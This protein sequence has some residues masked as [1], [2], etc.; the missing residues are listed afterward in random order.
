MF[1]INFN[2]YKPAYNNNYVITDRDRKTRKYKIIQQYVND[3]FCI[4]SFPGIRTY[5]D[6][7]TK[8]ERKKPLFNVKWHSINKKNHLSY[9]NFSDECFAFVAGKCSGV[10]VIDVDDIK[11]YRRMLKKY[12]ELKKYRTIKTKKG[13]HIYC[14]YDQSIQTRTDSMLDYKKVDI[15][16]DLSLAFCPPSFYILVNG[17]RVDYTDLGGQILQ[18]PP[19]LKKNLK[20][21]HEPNLPQF[22]MIIN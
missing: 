13:V 20:Q 6:P 18:F 21:F 22:E 9:L 17:T 16:N 14:L 12:P 3:G 15:R 1:E 2:V 10:T 4:F 5:I 11:E 8:I 19:G 7:T